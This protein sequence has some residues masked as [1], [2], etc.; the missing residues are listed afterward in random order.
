MN[1]LCI[2]NLLSSTNIFCFTVFWCEFFHY[3]LYFHKGS[4]SW[5][6]ALVNGRSDDDVGV[7]LVDYGHNMTAKS[8]HLRSIT[9]KLL[10]LPFQAVCCWLAGKNNN[11]QQTI[12]EFTCD[13]WA[14]FF[15]NRHLLMLSVNYKYSFSLC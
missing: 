7:Y 4:G 10:T 11:N 8:S 13:K 2:F 6:R 15:P 3:A 12:S 9:P 14:C 5:C 1:H